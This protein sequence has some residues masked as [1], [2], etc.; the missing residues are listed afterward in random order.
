M[1]PVAEDNKLPKRWK[2]VKILDT[3]E[4]ANS[5]RQELLSSDET[6]KLQV[7]IRRCGDGGSRFKVKSWYPS[8][9]KTSKK[10]K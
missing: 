6:A 5:L 8:A 2:N 4:S 9:D 3:Y 7:K 10:G 1:K